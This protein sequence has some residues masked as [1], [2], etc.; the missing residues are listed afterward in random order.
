ML[1]I[2]EILGYVFIGFIGM[3]GLAIFYLPF[4]ILLRKRVSIPRQTAFFLLGVCVLVIL[5]ATVCGSVIDRVALGEGLLAKNRS[6]NIIPFHFLTESWTMG[7]RK[8]VTQSFANIVMF[9]PLG[10]ILP[11][12][13]PYTRKLWKTTV[14][15]A[16]F[17][18]MIEFMQYFIGRSADIDDLMLNTLCGMIV[19]AFYLLS[20]TLLKQKKLWIQFTGNRN[21]DTCEKAGS[22]AE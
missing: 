13:V 4:C 3:L 6:Y 22:E 10:F 1:F 18:F 19:Y 8:Q 16:L 21:N 7:A 9:I 20:S 11:A 15:M 14:F 2:Q 12:A 17:S 5:A